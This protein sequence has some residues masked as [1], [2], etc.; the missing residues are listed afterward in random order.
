MKINLKENNL[1][2]LR[3]IFACQ[4]MLGHA[5]G[6]S[7]GARFFLGGFL[8]YIPGVPAFFFLSGFLIYASFEKSPDI[9]NYFLNRIYRLWPGLIL[10]TIGGLLFVISARLKLDFSQGTV[11]E[12]ATWLFAQIT[13]GQAVNPDSFRNLGTGVVNGALWTITVE[14]LF[15]IS[16]PFIVWIERKV[17]YFVPLL[18]ILSFIFFSFGEILL[19]NWNLGEKNL[20][21][22][23]KLTPV[24]WGWMFLVGVLAFKNISVIQKYFRF[25]WLGLPI[26]VVCLLI[27][28]PDSVFF[29]ST[30]NRLGLI[31]F[32]GY[33]SVIVYLGFGLRALKLD[34]DISYGVYIWHMVVINFFLV[35][36]YYTVFNVVVTTLVIAFFS[37]F[38]VEKPAL[39]FKKSSIRN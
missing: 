33:C 27:G 36:G 22:Y 11:G 3:L 21:R 7:G 1:D 34:F 31:Y 39:E 28:A 20:Y 10:V 25:M 6:S 19:A 32:I 4:V 23:F 24:V 17:Q 16:V 30:G 35:F 8:D 15:Y 37:W 38:V 12:Y 14:I 5:F 18:A 26:M 2:W 9:Y 13:L 29:A